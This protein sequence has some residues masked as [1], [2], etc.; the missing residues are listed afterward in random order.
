[1]AAG[2]DRRAWLTPVLLAMVLIGLLV[3]SAV[4]WSH[5]REA[6]DPGVLVVSRD[7]TVNFFSLDHRHP[8]ADVDRV[9][10]LSTGTFKK[11]YAA[12]RNAIVSGIRRKKLI[13]TAVVP[14][15][16]D[17]RRGRRR[18]DHRQGRTYIGAV[19]HAP[20]TC[21]GERLVARL[22]PEAGWVMAMTPARITRVLAVCIAVATVLTVALAGGSKP[23]SIP[24]K[25]DA[26]GRFIVGTIPDKDAR[27]ALQA[28]VDA[29]PAALSYDYRSLERGLDAAT[30]MMTPS[31]A[32]QFR[33]TFESS[34]ARKAPGQQAVTSALV[35]GAGFVRKDDSGLVRCL[36]FVDQV[37]LSGKGRKESDPVKASRNRLLVDLRKEDGTW[38]VDGIEPF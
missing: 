34:A 12:E 24:A 8:D 20:R 32:K 36:V 38:K 18:V 27:E 9:L 23:Q 26:D 6:I 2:A 1:M 4:V 25:V 30:A 5:R 28:A 21:P 37:L 33:A 31:F 14:P 7:E 29:V 17:R 10:E 16:P 19:S 13:V 15:R 35:R 3:T 11:Q 22:G